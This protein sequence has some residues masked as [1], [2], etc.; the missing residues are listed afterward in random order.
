MV[1][2]DDRGRLQT[3]NADQPWHDLLRRPQS[4]DHVVQLY[5]DEAFLTRAVAHFMAVGLSQGE[6]GVIIA[7]PAHVRAF[8]ARLAATL[9]VETARARKQLVVLDAHTCLAQFMVDGRPDPPAFLA[10]ANGV[11]AR[12]RDAGYAKVRLFGEMVDLLWDQNLPATTTLEDLWNTVLAEHRVSLLCAY[13]IDNFDRHAHRGV[14]HQI[15]RSHSH[16]IPVEDYERFERAVDHA[17]RDVFGT[18][19]D[20]AGLRTFLGRGGEG[21]QMPAGQSALLALHDLRRDLAEEV[22]ERAGQHYR[23]ARP[24]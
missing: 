16:L 21:P 6:A 22:L 7:T 4:R 10:L 3:M 23:R 11:L 12:V 15:S 14:L 8:T 19:G 5:T 17:Y 9:D 20:A 2:R 18:P 1:N 13:R 24:A